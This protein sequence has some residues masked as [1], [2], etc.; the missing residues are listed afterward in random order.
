MSDRM[1]MIAEA[2]ALLRGAGTA[3][4]GTLGADGAPFVSFATPG[5]RVDGTPLLFLSDLAVHTKNLKADPRVALMVD[6]TA[7]R[8]DPMTGPRLSLSGQAA[9][10]TSDDD[11]RRYLARHPAAE[12]YAQLPDFRIY[13]V[14]LDDAVFV[15]GFGRAR[16][17]PPRDILQGAAAAEIGAG[18]KGVV[19]HMNADHAD[20]I[21][22]YAT[23]LLD[24]EPGPWRMTG[25]DPDGADLRLGDLYARLP[26]PAPVTD[27]QAMRATLVDLVRMARKNG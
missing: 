4:L 17:L 15:A 8:A 11:R 6:D 25:V 5:L 1:A 20:A 24:R 2:R 27:L 19:D 12:R 26:F 21:E 23:G 7:G 10:S 3:A 16:S 9:P 22:A 13:A 18:E 14:T